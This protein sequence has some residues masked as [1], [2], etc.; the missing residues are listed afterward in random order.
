LAK[1]AKTGQIVRPPKKLN[2]K[3][4]GDAPGRHWPL[5]FSEAKSLKWRRAIAVKP[6]K[7]I[8]AIGIDGNGRHPDETVDLGSESA[9]ASP[10]IIQVRDTLAA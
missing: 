3:H 6:H 10:S 7:R 8:H 1:P 4:F 2:S 5:V 9:T